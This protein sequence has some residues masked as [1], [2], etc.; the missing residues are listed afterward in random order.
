MKSSDILVEEEEKEK[1]SNLLGAEL[2]TYGG[3]FRTATA[4]SSSD[5]TS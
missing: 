4:H 5:V 3:L 1:S 2:V